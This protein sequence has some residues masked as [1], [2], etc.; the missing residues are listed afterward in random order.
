MKKLLLSIVMIQCLVF[1]AFAADAVTFD[2]S[3]N[4]VIVTTTQDNYAARYLRRG[5]REPFRIPYWNRIDAAEVLS[6]KDITLDA[7]EA[8]ATRYD[9]DLV[10]VP[11][12]NFWY[13]RTYHTFFRFND[14][15]YTEYSYRFSI[16]IYNHTTKEMESY[17][18]SGRGRDEAI[19][20]H[21][22]DDVLHPALAR[23]L[24]KIPYK[25]IPKERRYTNPDTPNLQ[26][27][28]TE[29]GARIYKSPYSAV[30]I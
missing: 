8:L 11:F 26:L 16:Y 7:L 27:H 5:I 3:L 12:V 9:G 19:A 30:S 13:W 24:E 18:V 2:D 28:T 23:L 6:S 29:G 25:R 14:E 10:I 20:L 1:S 15:L 22:P 21:D 17:E 4:V